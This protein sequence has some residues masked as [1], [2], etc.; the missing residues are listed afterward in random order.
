[1]KSITSLLLSLAVTATATAATPFV[2]N[3]SP[4]LKFAGATR[5]IEKLVKKSPLQRRGNVDFSKPNVKKAPTLK[6]AS[7]AE[8]TT[9][10]EE[11]FSKFTAGSEASPDGTSLSDLNTAVIPDSYLNGSGLSGYP[12]YQ[13]GGC[14]YIGTFNYNGSAYTGSLFTPDFDASGNLVVSFRAKSELSGGEQMCVGHYWYDYDANKSNEIAYKILNI[15]NSWQTFEVSF[16]S[17]T[18]AESYLIWYSQSAGLYIDDIKVQSVKV[19][20]AAPKATT[21]TNYTGTSFIANWSEVAEATSYLLTVYTLDGDAQIDILT[22][23]EV[24]GTSYEVTGLDV[25]AVY[26]YYVK[27]KNDQ[28]TSQKSNTIEVNTIAVPVFN[29]PTVTDDGFVA[30]WNASPRAN[31][32]EFWAYERLTAKKGE[33]IT[34]AETN[35]DEIVSE[36][37]IGAPEEPEAVTA[38]IES[39]PGWLLYFPVYINGAVGINDYYSIME[40]PTYLDSPDYDLTISG[41]KIK[42]DVDIYS[43]DN[44]AIIL[45]NY[46]S[47]TGG[48]EYSDYYEITDAAA[49]WKTH[50]VELTGGTDRSLVCICG[51]GYNYTFIDNLKVTVVAEQDGFFDKP[52]LQAVTAETSVKVTADMSAGKTYAYKA[53]AGYLAQNDTETTVVGEYSDLQTVTGQNGGVGSTAFDGVAA[54]VAGGKLNVENPEGLPVAVY[55]AN[56]SLV[57]TSASA[58]I[59]LPARGVYVVKIGNKVFKVVK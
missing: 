8:L 10:L 4:A 35:F 34:L 27:A 31:Q 47:A 16:D 2:R 41:G 46:N 20:L 7:D 19:N 56:G 13:A 11:D 37:T 32:Y 15:T 28:Y 1:M 51:I 5:P 6:A 54:Y 18:D 44:V 24:T 43:T 57:S 58:T 48:Y 55:S 36:G 45:Y 12:I 49:Q 53:R 14:A 17:F 23:K 33:T 21:Y 25:N 59:D 3:D 39:L 50:S 30:S 40:Y 22:D 42:V 52:I 9:I 29:E 26:Y 38:S